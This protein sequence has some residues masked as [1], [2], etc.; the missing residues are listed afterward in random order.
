MR[1]VVR[2]LTASDCRKAEKRVFSDF[3]SRPFFGWI[4]FLNAT[5]SR[6][7]MISNHS[8][9]WFCSI[10]LAV[11]IQFSGDSDPFMCHFFV[12]TSRRTFHQTQSQIEGEKVAEE[13]QVRDQTEEAKYFV[14]FSSL[15]S[16]SVT[17]PWLVWWALLIFGT[18]RI[19]AGWR[20]ITPQNTASQ[21]HSSWS[22]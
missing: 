17:A 3:P 12:T 14:F 21:V 7:T 10:S 4:S 13:K 15:V 19:C 18:V 1:L 9:H 2:I 5:E 22:L 6:L 20:A 16:F 8:K 11:L